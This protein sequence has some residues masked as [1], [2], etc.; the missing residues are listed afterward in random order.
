MHRY[1]LSFLLCGLLALGAGCATSKPQADGAD[2]EIWAK[3]PQEGEDFHDLPSD[4]P[5][6]PPVVEGGQIGLYTEPGV[7]TEPPPV[8]IED[9]QYVVKRAELEG[10]LSQGPRHVL[11]MVQVQPAF[12]G[13]QFIGYELMG[14]SPS[15]T[16]RFRDRL[17]TGDVVVAI[18]QQSVAR[19]E[20][21]MSVW[22]SLRDQHLITL[23]VLRQGQSLEVTWPVVD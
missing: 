18:N 7:Q 14:F 4:L 17:Q 15:V 8:D 2:Q 20:D 23:T 13:S 22:R 16:P 5:K 19:P 11:V 10:F 12:R 21:Y 3:P 1:A 9:A 6:G